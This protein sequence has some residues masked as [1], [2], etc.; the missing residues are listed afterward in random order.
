MHQTPRQ[1]SGCGALCHRVVRQQAQAACASDLPWEIETLRC[2]PKQLQLLGRRGHAQT[3]ATFGAATAY[4]E[5]AST[6]FHA[7]SETMGA[8]PT[9]IMWLVCT[10]HDTLL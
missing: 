9:N 8:L 2:Q 6:G 4:Y 7:G 1:N 5:T 10:L 3:L